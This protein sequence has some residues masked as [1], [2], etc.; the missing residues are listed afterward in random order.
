MKHKIHI[1]KNTVINAKPRPLSGYIREKETAG[2][3]KYGKNVWIGSGCVISTCITLGNNVIISDGTYIEDNVT[4]DSDSILVYKC[5]VCA[6]TKIG[7]NCVIGGFI[8]ENTIIKNNCRIFGEIVHKHLDPSKN[9]DAP[10]SA[11]KGPVI[12][13]N[14]FIGFGAKITKPVEIGSNS[15]IL[16]NSIVSKDIPPFHI[17]RGINEI[18][19]YKEWK[20]GLS[21]SNFFNKEAGFV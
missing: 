2:R 1:G 20:G 13:D 10:D 11:E 14:V 9:W 19:Y 18:F 12:F 7:K 4:I 6:D 8:G 16:P 21:K 17:A 3:L 15:Y 5:L